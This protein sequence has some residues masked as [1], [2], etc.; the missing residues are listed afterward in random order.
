MKK[1]LLE[2]HDVLNRIKDGPTLLNSVNRCY[3]IV[4]IE[5]CLNKEDIASM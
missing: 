1:A 4:A 3:V 2:S 5:S